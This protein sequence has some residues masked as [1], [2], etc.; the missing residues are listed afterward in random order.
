[1]LEN[2]IL[3]HVSKVQN[4]NATIH[5][6][7]LG[8][9]MQLFKGWNGFAKVFFWHFEKVLGATIKL[10]SAKIFYYTKSTYGQDFKLYKK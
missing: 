1:M 6:P 9:K 10:L 7:I 5:C 4:L 3:I 8:Y 2:F